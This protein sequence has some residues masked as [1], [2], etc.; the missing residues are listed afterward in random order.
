MTVERSREY[1]SVEIVIEVRSYALIELW[2]M[3]SKPDE[4]VRLLATFV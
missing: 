1:V 3:Y 2:G 4:T